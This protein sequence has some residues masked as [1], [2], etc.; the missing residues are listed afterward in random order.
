MGSDSPL[1]RTPLA[2]ISTVR[3]QD[4][5]V[6]GLALLWLAVYRWVRV[7]PHLRHIPKVP[8]LPLLRSYLSG[9]V[10]E[11]RVKRVILPFAEKARTNVVLVFIVGEWQ[12]HVLEGKA[13]RQFM[14]NRTLMKQQPPSHML[15]WRLTGNQNVFMA[16]GEMWKRHANIVHEA[17]RR[18]TPIEQF[19]NLARKTFS[20]MGK[21]GRIRWNDYTHRFTLD[22]VGTTIIGY[23]F[24]ALD[25]P[26]G[27]F[28]KKYHDVMDAISS[29]AYIFL[30]FL[31]RWWPRH[32]VRR[33]VD[34]FVDDFRV[35][36]ENKRKDP[37][38]DM[39]TYMF[40]DPEMTD[41]EFRDNAIVAFMG[42]HDT[43]AGALSSLVHFLGMHQDVQAKA[44]EEVFAVMGSDDPSLEYFAK[45]PYLNAIVREAMRCNGPSNVTIPRLADV[46]LQVGDYVIPANTPIVLNMCAILHNPALW[47]SPSEFDPDRFTKMDKL[48]E[49][50]INFGLGP[51]QCPAR[52]F[53]IN[54]QKTLFSMLLREY[55]WTVPK[56]SIHR[57]YIK[58]GFSTFA[59]SLPYDVD[60]DFVKI[61]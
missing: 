23:D 45:M 53:S 5:L 11:Q 29:P 10:E 26:D 24:E 56:D 27:V 55:R 41:V 14:E 32:E 47:P 60:I 28:V 50:L 17:L 2:V 40:E 51:R 35:L 21:G 15:L 16:E 8:I 46:P 31:E 9:E 44:R 37:G 39:L 22:A 20:L 7:P 13:G 12:V 54:E 38:N 3:L 4:V 57:D 18:S 25:K 43:T 36:V 34:E 61:T 58:N 6:V 59:L 33:L 1:L 52:N 30:P 19:A 49:N 42:G 48:D